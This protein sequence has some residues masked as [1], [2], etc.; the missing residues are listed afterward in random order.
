MRSYSGY[1]VLFCILVLLGVF[2][3][4]SPSLTA[5]FYLDDFD[6]IVNNQL[7]K[8]DSLGDL[9]QS[10]YRSRFLGYA[11]FWSNYQIS[12]GDVFG[13]RLTNIILHLVNFLLIFW[14]TFIIFN[15]LADSK[16]DGANSF[17]ESN[18]FWALV[19][20]TLW[21]F[22]PLNSQVV[23]YVVQRLASVAS[24]FM[25]LSAISYIKAREA[26]GIK[27]VTFWALLFVLSVSIGV[28]SK[29]NYFAILIF[30]FLW[31]LYKTNS[32]WRHKILKFCLAALVGFCF[33]A[34]FISELL[35][36]L[37]TYTRDPGATSRANYFY[38]QQIIL[39]DYVFRFLMPYQLQ[40]N[41]DAIQYRSF[42]P[43]VCLAFLSH[44]LVFVAAIRFR[45]EI[46]L[47]FI[48]IALFYSSHSVESFIIPIKDLA[49]EHRT[50]L[51]NLGLL[52]AFFALFK[53]WIARLRLN[54]KII[55]IQIGV[56]LLILSGMTKIYLRSLE[57]QE[58]F[59]FY[60]K[61][62]EL[63]PMHY[64]SNGSYG[65]ELARKGMLAEAEIYL[66]K[67]IEISA[68]NGNMTVGA[69]NAYM[70]VMYQQ[71]K[72]Q[73]AAP[74]VMKALKYIRNPG[75]RSILLSNLAVGYIHMGFCDFALGLLNQ[76]IK[77]EPNNLDARN[78]KNYCENR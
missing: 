59:S 49:F 16:R 42:E 70:T 77:L 15:S 1:S 32:L 68:K 43:L 3:A 78:N 65:I 74:I 60:K 10:H 66:A 38:S 28:F 33:V 71:R 51:G 25:L 58:P 67:S 23:I 4:Y 12:G 14:L 72:Y 22:H 7:I 64:R 18:T 2:L 45:K 11:S 21:V 41:V 50:Y 52:I 37:D 30:L 34:P 6:S 44:I 75:Q 35:H 31:E 27:N 69:V 56:L 29:Q 53:Y 17:W 5:P 26:K 73:R 47:F 54:V 36:S 61:E 48:G 40:L 8:K 24:I 13:F 63:A 20:A 9:W 62:V 19:I 46:P 57:W 76:A 39:W 55:H